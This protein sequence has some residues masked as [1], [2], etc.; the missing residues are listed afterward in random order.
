MHGRH[1]CSDSG[2]VTL[3]AAITLFLA[4]AFIGALAV[5]GCLRE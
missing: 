1:D 4:L 5:A 2:T 3:A